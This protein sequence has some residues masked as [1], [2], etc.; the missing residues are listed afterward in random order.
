MPGTQ[1]PFL[2]ACLSFLDKRTTRKIPGTKTDEHI[3][4]LRLKDDETN[5]RGVAD[6]FTIVPNASHT[7]PNYMLCRRRKQHQR[8]SRPLYDSKTT[9]LAP[10]VQPPFLRPCRAL[11][12][13]TSILQL[14]TDETIVAPDTQPPMLRENNDRQSYPYQT[15][16]L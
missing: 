11:D 12:T 6:L 1:S 2:R 4:T 13:Q 16:Q 15:S 8:H 3:S 9:R 14:K 5:T 7:N 10:Y